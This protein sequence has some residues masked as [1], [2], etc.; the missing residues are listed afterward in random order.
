MDCKVFFQKTKSELNLIS[1]FDVVCFPHSAR[2][3]NGYGTF[4]ISGGHT[5]L[6]DAK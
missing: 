4:S 5:F 3:D 2:I 1:V 6:I